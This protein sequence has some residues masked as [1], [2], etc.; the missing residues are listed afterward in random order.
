MSQNSEWRREEWKRQKYE[1]LQVLTA[2]MTVM[3]AVKTCSYLYFCRFHSS[4]VITLLRYAPSTLYQTS[5]RSLAAN[6][7]RNTIYYSVL[8]QKN[9]R[10]IAD[11][12]GIP[13]WSVPCPPSRLVPSHMLLVPSYLKR[14]GRSSQLGPSTRRTRVLALLTLNSLSS[15]PYFR[16]SIDFQ[17]ST[18]W[19]RPLA[20]RNGH[21]KII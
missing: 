17:A 13:Q 21:V 10:V 20:E 1:W 18:E 9:G 12:C 5:D 2:V 15:S 8:Y 16:R 11:H 6:P 4:H 7:T 14:P 19:S 3:T